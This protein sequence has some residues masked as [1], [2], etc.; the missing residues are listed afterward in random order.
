MKYTVLLIFMFAAIFG[1]AQEFMGVK[2]EGDKTK[3]ISEFIIKGFVLKSDKKQDAVLMEGNVGGK[4]Y[5]IVIAV[6]P[7]T[8]QVWKLFVYL[9]KSDNW[10]RIKSD[11]NEYLDLLIAKYGKPEHTYAF[12]ESP[13]EDGDGYEMNA[14]S[15]EKC[16]YSAFWN[17]IIGV[18]IDISKFKQ[19]RVSYE[20]KKNAELHDLE[21][22]EL[23]SKIF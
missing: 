23:N 4:T 13:Y 6:T 15:L 21:K 9:P 7:K 11:Y 10:N 5:E 17:D 22:K 2:V 14:V 18:S 12:F 16:H 1:N 20:N 8:K 3:L 19:V